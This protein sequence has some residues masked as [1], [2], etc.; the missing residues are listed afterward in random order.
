[1]VTRETLKKEIDHVQDKYLGV[2]FKILKTFEIP[3]EFDGLVEIENKPRNNLV[4]FFENSPLYNSGIEVER[5]KD[6]GREVK[7]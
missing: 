2:L 1:M 6:F 3:D 4:E 5:D 7:I